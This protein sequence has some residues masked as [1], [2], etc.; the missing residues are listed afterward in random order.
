M[1]PTMSCWCGTGEGLDT[2]E[3][4]AFA[5]LDMNENIS[6]INESIY[7][8]WHGDAMLR[9]AMA[10]KLVQAAV[11]SGAVALF[12]YPEVGFRMSGVEMLGDEMANDLLEC[13]V[14]ACSVATKTT[15]PFGVATLFSPWGKGNYKN[16][17]F[18]LRCRQAL[19]VLT[20]MVIDQT[21]A[22][23]HEHPGGLFVVTAVILYDSYTAGV[24][25]VSNGFR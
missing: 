20:A 18:L 8:P 16:M 13:L 7:L 2:A 25:L 9:V 5:S 10:V 12:A 14:V 21:K 15:I 19:A 11:A 23:A 17:L 24:Q 3:R 22:I 6:N 1:T 4:G